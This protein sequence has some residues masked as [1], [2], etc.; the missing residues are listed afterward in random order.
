MVPGKI[1]KYSRSVSIIGV[2]AMPFGDTGENPEL[3]GLT[4]G[5]FFGAS[6]LMAME[7]EN[8]GERRKLQKR[9]T[10]KDGKRV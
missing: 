2:G 5:E 7:K 4:E 3:K 1:G 6:A 9:K 8:F 10:Q